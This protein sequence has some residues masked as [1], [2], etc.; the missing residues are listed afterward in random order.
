MKKLKQ[1]MSEYWIR[2]YRCLVLEDGTKCKFN[3]FLELCDWLGIGLPD[4]E[5]HFDA[6]RAYAEKL[7]SLGKHDEAR[8]VRAAIASQEDIARRV[9]R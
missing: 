1:A 4:L 8:H 7:E 2:R 9:K 5:L 6:Q 3:P